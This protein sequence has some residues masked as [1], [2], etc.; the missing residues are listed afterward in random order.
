VLDILTAFNDEAQMKH[1][2]LGLL[3]LVI[4]SLFLAAQQEE[5]LWMPEGYRLLT[6]E[7][8]QALPPE[9]VKAIG[10]RNSDLLLQAVRAM[11]PA[12]RQRVQESLQR[13]IEN[14]ELSQIEKQYVTM[15]SMVLLAVPTEEHDRAQREEERQKFEKLLRDQEETTKGFP[16]STA[17][18][19]RRSPST[20][21]R[22]LRSD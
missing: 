21:W 17:I 15:A 22:P 8:H 14:R 6:I 19:R 11:S 2:R 4:P 12:E 10:Q 1:W 3:L 16:G 5:R 18:S 20:T 7:E 13:T 9:E